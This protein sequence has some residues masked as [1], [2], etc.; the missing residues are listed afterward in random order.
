MAYIIALDQGTTSSRAII[1]DHEQNIVDIRQNET[2]QYF[3]QSGWVEQDPQDIWASTFGALQETLA[4]TGISPETI[5]ALAITNQR[6][7]TIVWDKT[8]GKPVYNAIVW[9]CRRTADRCRDLVDQGYKDRIAEKT[10]L[11]IDPYFSATK[12]AWILDEVDPDRTRAKAGDLLFGTVDTWL[13]WKL[14]DGQV[15]A[16]DYTNASRTM[17]FNIH[18]LTWDQDI[19]DLLDIP[20]AMLPDVHPSSY[21]FGQA[22]LGRNV[23]VPVAGMAG[24]QQAALFG[25]TCF[26]PGEAKNTY[27]TGCFLL[28]NIGHEPIISRHGLVT[29]IAAGTS[30]QPTYALEGSIFVGGAVIQWL[31]DILHILDEA[32]DSDFFATKL[33]DNEGVY[34][35]PAFVG[36]GAPYWDAYARGAMF[37]LTRGTGRAHIVRAALEA[38]TYQTHDVLEAMVAESPV[39]IKTLQVDGGAAENDFLMQF[40]A[41]ILNVPVVRPQILETTALGAAMLAGL[42]VGV[43]KDLAEVARHRQVDQSFKPAMDGDKRQKNIDGWKEAIRRTLTKQV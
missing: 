36:L 38:I 33:E 29:T 34:L 3:P 39:E 19:L 11:V 6:E 20:R 22:H 24:D 35:V 17:L 16:T 37:G 21:S 30:D 9:Q 5:D 14:T 18:S 32:A 27:G 10:G 31:R 2:R 25:Q 15:H 23:M 8:T 4:A 43:W 1:F 41:D 13:L 26:S 28:M 7:T 40:Q 12:L 42:A